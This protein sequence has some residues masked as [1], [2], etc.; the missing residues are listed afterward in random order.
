MRPVWFYK[1]GALCQGVDFGSSSTPGIHRIKIVFIANQPAEGDTA[2][3][4]DELYETP[5]A[6]LAAQADKSTARTQQYLAAIKN[7]EDL[8]RFLLSHDTA[9]ENRDEDA[10]K[11]A[12]LA[13]Q[14]FGLKIR[15][16]E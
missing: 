5:S 1:W 6:C 7:V 11:A 13:T 14:N 4:A 2:C 8:I 3:R 10:R 12:I 9:S 15:I 16:N